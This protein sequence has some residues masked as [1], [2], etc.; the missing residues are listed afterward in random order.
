MDEVLSDTLKSGLRA[1]KSEEDKISALVQS[2]IAVVDCQRKTADRV[3]KLVSDS[4]KMRTILILLSAGLGYGANN[5]IN[6]LLTRLA[7]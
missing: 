4:W 3:K 5:I 7:G 1:A 2:M 6:S